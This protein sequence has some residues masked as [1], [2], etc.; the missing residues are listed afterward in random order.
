MSVRKRSART[1]AAAAD[2]R[3]LALALPEAVETLTWGEPHFRVDNKIFSGLGTREGR[4]V[5]SVKLEKAH[6]EARLLDPR[7]R[8]APYVGRYGWVEFALE[9]V[10][11]GELEALLGE[12][13]RLVAKTKRPR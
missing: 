12:S 2:L 9:D 11:V 1:G 5:S 7:F 4:A 10:S 13:H 3:R 6:A 8:P